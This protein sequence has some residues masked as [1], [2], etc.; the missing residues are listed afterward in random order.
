MRGIVVLVAVLAP[1]AA[2]AAPAPDVA[3]ARLGT[4]V[5][6]QQLRDNPLI[7]L[8]VE[9]KGGRADLLPDIRPAAIRA[10]NAT[11]D[12]LL[13]RLDR[14]DAAR[15]STRVLRRDHAIA[16]EMLEADRQLR[17][18]RNE[19]WSVS[20][21]SGWPSQFGQM[22]ELQPIATAKDRADS[23]ARW[24]AL[25]DYI[26]AD[27]DNLQQGLASGYVVPRTVAARVLAQVDGLLAGPVEES[28]F[29]AGA[30]KSGDA[31]FRAAF[32]TLVRDR[33]NPAI[34]RYRAFLADTYIPKA[35]AT[36]SVLDL[37]NGRA[38]YDAW[39][40]Y[41]TT[42]PRSGEQVMALGARTV[43]AN[44]T[45]VRAMG[46][47]LYG[48]DD[49]AAIVR[50]VRADPTERFASKDEIVAFNNALEE[51]ATAVS[52]A[53]LID[54]MPAQPLEVRPMS[55]AMDASGASSNYVSNADASKPAIYNLQV[56]KLEDAR[57][58]DMA[59]TAVH[60]GYPGHHLQFAYAAALP[61]TP[62][63]RISFNSAYAE[64]WARYAERMSDEVGL[65]DTPQAKILRRAWPARGMVADP[66]LHLQRWPREKVAAY[67]KETG[68]FPD[69]V[70]DDLAD[71][72]AIMPG[73]LTAYDSGGLEIV[74]LRDA[75]KR[76]VGARFDLKAFNAVVLG[77]GI[78]PL[79]LLRSNVAAW[80]AGQRGAVTRRPTAA[81]SPPRAR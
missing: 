5:V 55:D 48:T 59:I 47:P 76:A 8:F 20:H 68:R 9:V 4:D 23:L 30:K 63:S 27:I 70:L 57:R 51:R 38:C 71:R 74:A 33:I 42:L 26:A 10:H 18:C 37:P 11:V 50:K 56:G 58:A 43:A 62:L 21:M 3:M 13:A 12:T 16:R 7:P 31:A 64:G 60:E 66:G 34:R 6:A 29:Y 73:Q 32:A 2:R 45:D 1:V 67:V 72:V 36:L 22:T 79:A 44:V 17:V 41:Y 81:R 14:I 40:R 25:P 15:L 49:F 24:G 75:A 39:L 54:H 46:K 35:R 65:L 52:A 77:D 28:P 69:A 80:I 78:V 61:S 19:L 53:R